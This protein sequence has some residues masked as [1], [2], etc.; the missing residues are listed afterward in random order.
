MSEENP[1]VE[2]GEAQRR[3]RRSRATIYRWVQEGKVRTWRP[4]VK[5]MFHVGDLLAAEKETQG[6]G[7][8]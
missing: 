1:W 3:T 5:R 4:I 2:L 7:L 8:R 6:R